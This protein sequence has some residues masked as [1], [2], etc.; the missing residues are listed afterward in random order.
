MGEQDKGIVVSTNEFKLRA[1]FIVL[2]LL[3]VCVCVFLG[4]GEILTDPS[5]IKSGEKG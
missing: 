5:V 2:Q 3:C 1:V 4:V